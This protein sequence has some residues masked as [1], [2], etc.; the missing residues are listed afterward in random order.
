MDTRGDLG[1]N[2]NKEGSKAANELH[3]VTPRPCPAEENILK[4]GP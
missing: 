2:R 4:T 3:P 1:E